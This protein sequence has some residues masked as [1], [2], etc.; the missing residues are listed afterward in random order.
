MNNGT[1]Q[2]GP[3]SISHYHESSLSRIKSRS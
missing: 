1:V 3:K 2:C